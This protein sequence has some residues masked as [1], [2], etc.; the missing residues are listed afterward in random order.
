MKFFQISPTYSEFLSFLN[1][2][3]Q[4]CAGMCNF[5][6]IFKPNVTQRRSFETYKLD[7]MRAF[8]HNYIPHDYQMKFKNIRMGTKN[9]FKR[10][11][12]SNESY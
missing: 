2:S 3:I 10:Q 6:H 8:L 5:T 7:F 1:N 9:N 12:Q 4:S 11:K